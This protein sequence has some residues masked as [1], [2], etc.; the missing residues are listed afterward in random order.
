MAEKKRNKVLQWSRQSPD[1][2]LTDMQR[3]V[4]G[5]MPAD[6]RLY[7]IIIE[8]AEDQKWFSYYALTRITRLRIFFL[9]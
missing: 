8:P 2:L 5:R 6:L 7:L 3:A 9:Q 1:L 4:H